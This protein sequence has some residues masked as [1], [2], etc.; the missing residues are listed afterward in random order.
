[1]TSGDIR[2]RVARNSHD[3]EDLYDLSSQANAILRM[4]GNRMDELLAAQDEHTATLS[5]HTAT[6][7]EHTTTLA[8]HTATL[9]EHGAKL[10]QILDR[11]PPRG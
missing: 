3:I 1:M 11:L 2:R 5:E 6:L 7:A 9:A 4:Q 10:D 8:E